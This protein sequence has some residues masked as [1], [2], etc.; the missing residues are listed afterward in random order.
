MKEVTQVLNVIKS[1]KGM[2]LIELIIAIGLISVIITLGLMFYFTGVRAFDR[3][4][5]RADIQQNVRHSISFISKRLL[6]ASDETVRVIP[7]TSANEELIIG[8]EH[9]RLNSVT[10]AL[11][12]NHNPTNSLSPFNPLAENITA[13]NVTSTVTTTGRMITVTI[14]GGSTQEPNLFTLETQVFLKT[15]SPLR[16]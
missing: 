10:L 11:E 15:P 6:N 5:D 4:V 14:I 3:N 9:F 13:F 1:K 7:T 2:T 12:V 16:R 8:L